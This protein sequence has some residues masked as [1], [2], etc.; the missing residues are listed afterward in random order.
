MR[1]ARRESD[2]DATADSNPERVL[3]E[4]HRV[5]TTSTALHEVGGQQS[6]PQSL[7]AALK[8]LATPLPRIRLENTLDAKTD[9]PVSDKSP[10]SSN[11]PTHL[12][13]S[14]K[15][16]SSLPK[17][18]GTTSS[19]VE[20]AVVR[21]TKDVSEPQNQAQLRRSYPCSKLRSEVPWPRVSK[22]LPFLWQCRRLYK[23]V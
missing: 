12:T 14:V 19:M 7:K 8:E 11:L 1:S 13:S 22:V 2:E 4:D 16:N 10:A 17:Q 6:A 5:T 20:D 23:S 21:L 9:Q 3:C 15:S 18:I